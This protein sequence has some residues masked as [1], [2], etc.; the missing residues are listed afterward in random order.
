M[1]KKRYAQ[2]WACTQLFG[3]NTYNLAEYEYFLME[4]TP[5]EIDLYIHMFSVI[6]N[7]THAKKVLYLVSASLAISSTVNFFIE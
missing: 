4:P 7:S 3:H 6:Y 1:F 2:I 5:F